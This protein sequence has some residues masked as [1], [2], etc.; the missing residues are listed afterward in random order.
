ML[1]VLLLAALEAVSPVGG[2]EISVVP[3]CQR[4]LAALETVD[5]RSRL[6]KEFATV[7]GWA[8]SDCDGFNSDLQGGW[9]IVFSDGRTLTAA[10]VPTNAVSVVSD[11]GIRS[12]TYETTDVRV[13][14][15]ARRAADRTDLCARV[16]SLRKTVKAVELPARL[17]FDPT[18]CRRLVFPADKSVGTGFAFKGAFFAEG[19]DP[20]GLWSGSVRPAGCWQTVLP[21]RMSGEALDCEPVAVSVTPAGQRLLPSE[22]VALLKTNNSFRVNRA[23]AR[24]DADL[25]LAD[26]ENGPF[27]SGSSLGGKGILWRIGQADPRADPTVHRELIRGLG[28]AAVGGRKAARLAVISLSRGPKAGS[29]VCGLSVDDIVAELAKLGEVVRLDAAAVMKGDWIGTTFDVIVNPYGERFPCAAADRIR[30]AEQALVAY[31]RGGGQWLELGGAS[32]HTPLCPVKYHRYAGDYPSLFC[33]FFRL[34]DDRGGATT[35]YSVRKRPFVPGRLA[36]GGDARGGYVEHGFATWIRPN[37]EWLSPIVRIRRGYSLQDDAD[38]YVADNG[39]GRPLA[40]KAGPVLGTLRKAPLFFLAGSANELRAAVPRLRVPT[41]VHTSQYLY[42][43]FDRQYPDHLPPRS[44]FGTPCEF[45]ATLDALHAAGHLFSPYTNPTW[46]CDDPKGP[47]F[48]AAG[49]CA[50][51]RDERGRPCKCYY[52][53][54]ATGFAVSFFHPDVRAANARTLEAFVRDYPSD[55]LFQDECGAR[56]LAYDFNAAAPSP[57]SYIDGLLTMLEGDGRR[58][59]LATEEGWDQVAARETMLCGLHWRTVPLAEK[60]RNDCQRLI[61]ND[62]PPELWEYE[63]LAQRMM[64]DK[65]L[66]LLHDLAGFVHGRRALAWCLALG[67]HLSVRMSAKDLEKSAFLREWYEWIAEFQRRVVSRMDGGRA[68]AFRHDRA[69]LFAR[70]GDACSRLDDGVVTARYGDVDLTV[71]LGDVPR[72]ACGRRLAAYGWLI[73]APGLEAEYLE[74]KRPIIRDA[75]GNAEYKGRIR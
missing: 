34:E 27:I 28:F 9:R 16:K 66:F 39:L 55:V 74:G 51:S 30:E 38:A 46:W 12:A 33:D 20:S 26:S 65:C 63:N 17:R 56:H 24:E 43:G 47:T 73:S 48:R 50:V 42:G 4:R 64:H 2:V 71:N 35:V 75:E 41:L 25:V 61:K 13:T 7:V 8:F 53:P 14:V 6:L 32:F 36:C 67:Y 3:Q 37:E 69:P 57:T 62:L 22:V 70:G 44:A 5:E 68:T 45:R 21:H 19:G 59:P 29:F 31:V 1:S 72:E 23:T 15:E 52:G 60:A 40:E 49:D 18:H 11:K 10:D 58:I 54:G